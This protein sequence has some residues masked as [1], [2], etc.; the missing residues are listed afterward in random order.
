MRTRDGFRP[1]RT[2]SPNPTTC[3]Q[4]H[5]FRTLP[6]RE[7]SAA[8]CAVPLILRVETDLK[9]F[10]AASPKHIGG[11]TLIMGNMV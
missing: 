7:K 9:L 5:A 11:A 6:C 4:N 10:F 1:R 2:A 8:T 3:H